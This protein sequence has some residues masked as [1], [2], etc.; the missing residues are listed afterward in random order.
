[1]DVAYLYDDLRGKWQKQKKLT[2]YKGS[3]KRWSVL[4]A[5]HS[6]ETRN[7]AQKHLGDQRT[8]PSG[9]DGGSYEIQVRKEQQLFV[10]DNANE[11]VIELPRKSTYI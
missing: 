6:E 9:L 5:S 2:L 10:E 1:M 3:A 11:E 8:T 7:I 4:D